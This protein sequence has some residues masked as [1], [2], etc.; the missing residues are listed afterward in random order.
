YA[1]G[2]AY[3]VH[4][5]VLLNYNADYE[6]LTTLA[7]E[8]GHAMHSY[9]ANRAQP[10]PTADYSIFLAEIASTFGEALLSDRLL[11]TE[12]GRQERI[13]PTSYWLDGM[14]ATLFRQT[15]FAE[16][17]LAIHETAERGEALTGE[18]LSET[19]LE[20]VRR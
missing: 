17:E 9:L 10:Y 6:S 13:Y 11:R 1:T 5:Y 7:H 8:M 18:T 14:R 20:L 12:T 4:P 3:D 16:F 2:A 15:L 19:Y